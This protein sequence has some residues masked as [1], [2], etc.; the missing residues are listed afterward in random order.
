MKKG[1]RKILTREQIVASL[2]SPREWVKKVPSNVREMANEALRDKRRA[3]IGKNEDFG[4]F[5]VSLQRKTNNFI[6]D[7]TEK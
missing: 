3:A 7:W 1:K 4:F 6:L 2:I 5:V